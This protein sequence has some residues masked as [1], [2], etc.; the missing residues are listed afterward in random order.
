MT[1][2]LV[3]TGTY[4]NDGTGDTLRVSFNKVNENFI[5]VYNNI[6]YLANVSNDINT[7]A[8]QNYTM[9]FDQ[10][11]AAFYK[12]NSAEFFAVQVEATIGYAFLQSNTAY[13]K[14]NGTVTNTASS[15]ARANL[16]FDIANNLSQQIND[17]TQGLRNRTNS[18]YAF[19]KIGRAHV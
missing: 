12:A 14:A 11:N 3:Q 18:I 13:D 9:I 15:F 17:S 10:S 6:G 5:D 4:P 19:A 2:H 8:H 16:I 7:V 1:F